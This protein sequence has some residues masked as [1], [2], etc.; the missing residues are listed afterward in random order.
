MV[1]Y[2]VVTWRRGGER[3]VSD[4]VA[5]RRV[6]PAAGRLAV[7]RIAPNPSRGPARI[8]F[9]APAAGTGTLA[10]FD[11]AGRRVATRTVPLRGGEDSYRWN[12]RDERGRA[13]PPG[14]Y[15][16]RLT[17]HGES[18]VTRVLRTR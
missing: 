13:L 10:F 17:A 9:T 12:G 6:T 5:V 14:A 11:V 18:S 1:R 16:A 4:P 2:R 8:D 15:F 7:H 3:V